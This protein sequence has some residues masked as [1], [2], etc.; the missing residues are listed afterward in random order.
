MAVEQRI[1]PGNGSNKDIVRTFYSTWTCL[2]AIGL[3]QR[4]T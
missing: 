4:M 2:R 3:E 1:A